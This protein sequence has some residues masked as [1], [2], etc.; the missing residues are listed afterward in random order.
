MIKIATPKDIPVKENMEIIFRNPS[1]FL[2]FKYRKAIF[3][4]IVEINLN[5]FFY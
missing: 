1:F 4:S 2:G 5:F 3:R